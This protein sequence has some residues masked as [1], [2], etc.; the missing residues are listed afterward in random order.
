M[1]VL[2][3]SIACL[4]EGSNFCIFFFWSFGDLRAGDVQLI[5]A[6]YSGIPY[7]NVWVCP[8][9]IFKVKTDLKSVFSDEDCWIDY[10]V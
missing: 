6:V 9:G 8:V 2:L 7:L 5:Q 1:P 3:T 4:Y 10:G